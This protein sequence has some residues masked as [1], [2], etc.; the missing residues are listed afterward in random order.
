MYVLEILG[1]C[2]QYNCR[3]LYY[4][5]KPVIWFWDKRFLTTS[6]E[7][8]FGKKNG[9]LQLLQELTHANHVHLNVHVDLLGPC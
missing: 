2:G 8:R 7:S 9:D 3:V 5:V 4:T 6:A 1:Q